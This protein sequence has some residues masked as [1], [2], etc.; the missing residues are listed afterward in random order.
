[1][2]RKILK[3]KAKAE[4]LLPVDGEIEEVPLDG[5]CLFTAMA[6]QLF[7]S[8]EKHLELRRLAVD[9][10][11]ARAGDA[12]IPEM[13][14]ELNMDATTTESTVLAAYKTEYFKETTYGGVMEADSIGKLYNVSVEIYTPMPTSI[15]GD[16]LPEVLGA[17]ALGATGTVRLWYYGMQGGADPTQN[18]RH[19]DAIRMPGTTWPLVPPSPIELVDGLLKGPQDAVKLNLSSPAA[20]DIRAKLVAGPAVKAAADVRGFQQ[21]YVMSDIHAD[22][23]KFIRMLVDAGLVRIGDGVDTYTNPA[24]ALGSATWIAP[25]GTG[26]FVLGDLVDG[27]R[28]ASIPFP[29]AEFFLHALLFNLRIQAATTGSTVR[30]TVGNHD[31]HTV[32]LGAG[33]GLEEYISDRHLSIFEGDRAAQLAARR[34]FLRPFYEACPLFHI[35]LTA[36]DGGIEIAGVHAS[37][38]DSAGGS[39][40]EFLRAASE[41]LSHMGAGLYAT[42]ATVKGLAA[43]STSSPAPLWSR[44]YAEQNSCSK[45]E[46]AGMPRM[47]VVGHCPTNASRQPRIQELMAAD[48]YDQCD[49]GSGGMGCV[50]LDCSGE[51][52]G[53]RLAFVDTAL[54]QAFRAADNKAR[55]VEMLLLRHKQGL[56]TE[57]RWLNEIV[58]IQVGA[59]A[60]ATEQPVWSAEPAGGAAAAEEG[61]T[62][63]N[64]LAT[65]FAAMLL[66]AAL[67]AA[68]KPVDPAQAKADGRAAWATAKPALE[69]L[70]AGWGPRLAGLT[71]HPPPELATLQAD[72]AAFQAEIGTVDATI[73]TQE[74]YASWP[75][76]VAGLQ[77]TGVALGGR[78][79]AAEATSA[80]LAEIEGLNDLADLARQIE[81]ATNPA[82]KAA[83]FARYKTM[84]LEQMAAHIKDSRYKTPEPRAATAAEYS[85]RA[86][87]ATE[88]TAIRAENEGLVRYLKEELQKDVRAAIAKAIGIQNQLKKLPE[89]FNIASTPVLTAR[90]NRDVREVATRVI[91]ENK[92]ELAKERYTNLATKTIKELAPLPGTA[93]TSMEPT[94]RSVQTEIEKLRGWKDIV[95]RFMKIQK[96]ATTLLGNVQ[97]K[98]EDAQQDLRE[99]AT[100][101]QGV[102]TSTN[103]LK[104]FARPR[105]STVE[106]DIARIAEIK[107]SLGIA[108]E[109]DIPVG[110]TAG[111]TWFLNLFDPAEADPSG[112][113]DVAF[114]VRGCNARRLK[115]EVEDIA[116]NYFAKD[117][118]ASRKAYDPEVKKYI[119]MSAVLREELDALT[120]AATAAAYYDPL[121]TAA[122]EKPSEAKRLLDRKVEAL[123]AIAGGEELLTAFKAKIAEPIRQAFPDREVKVAG[124]VPGTYR[125]F[126]VINPYRGLSY[127]LDSSTKFEGD[128]SSDRDPSGGLVGANARLL[129]AVAP[130]NWIADTVAAT[131]LLESLWFCGQNPE[132]AAD[133]RCFPAKLLGELREHDAVAKARAQGADYI[134]TLVSKG[135]DPLYRGIKDPSGAKIPAWSF[136]AIEITAADE[137]AARKVVGDRTALGA[138]YGEYKRKIKQQMDEI[139]RASEIPAKIEGLIASATG[140]PEKLRDL[141]AFLASAT[142]KKEVL[143]R[144]AADLK[145]AWTAMDAAWG[146]ADAAETEKQMIEA[147]RSLGNLA[148]ILE[149]LRDV[150]VNADRRAKTVVVRAA[151]ATGTAI[152]AAASAVLTKGFG[153]PLRATALGAAS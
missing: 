60:P 104:G 9:Y 131:A 148:P 53:P 45:I 29:Y 128:G 88:Y 36:T 56:S 27:R 103:I 91:N 90:F 51:D 93:L 5:N 95:L 134:A 41:E 112:C 124:S 44:L 62:I 146:R 46:A 99:I 38:H 85:I 11:I 102:L 84:A 66:L 72:I 140:D 69:A 28:V 71:A 13:R 126:P 114:P 65:R 34:A 32:L 73:T 115:Q 135:L 37:L 59:G 89:S 49:K 138:R 63:A 16:V 106:S 139:R 18:V 144:E 150:D 82:E 141:Q 78:V 147:D 2:R 43:T 7:G 76:L 109:D 24:A 23:S 54:S 55:F 127:R 25:P 133:S 119:A 130:D 121:I 70:V 50:V 122:A 48:A 26:L 111:D 107:A 14:R 68:R 1:V 35:E 79:D 74:D 6:L 64:G 80:R 143:D 10:G 149:A 117:L 30:F 75:P 101:Y 12:E 125:T 153:A 132:L 15:S 67:H 3:E 39:A 136:P 96:D 113:T 22:F 83:L 137:E 77:A 100:R 116:P 123:E 108:P 105:D 8:V 52:V 151:E 145:T 129:Q 110:H 40:V 61:K 118:L 120:D 98:D 87:A 58:R 4:G 19:Y 42:G 81:A 17:D 152:R 97:L 94:L 86:T 31:L 20:W 57:K 92:I 47:T 142:E 33:G 21:V